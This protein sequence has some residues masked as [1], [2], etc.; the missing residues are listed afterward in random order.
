MHRAWIEGRCCLILAQA[1]STGSDRV[2]IPVDT[3]VL[4]H[5][6]DFTRPLLCTLCGLRM[7]HPPPYFAASGRG[8]QEVFGKG[9]GDICVLS[10]LEGEAR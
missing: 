4:L 9:P 1:F 10:F 8:T 7:C 5:E 2:N 6:P 3:P